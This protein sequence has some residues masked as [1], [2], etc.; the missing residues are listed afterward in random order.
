MQNG[1]I[2]I[3][4][5][6]GIVV[7]DNVVLN[8][9]HT[10][11]TLSAVQALDRALAQTAKTH[12]DRLCALGVYRYRRLRPADMPN[13]E[14]RALLAKTANAYAY[15]TVVTVL[16]APGLFNTTVRLFIAGLLSVSRMPNVIAESID[17]GVALL[18]VSGCQ[19][20]AVEPVLRRLVDRV[21]A[22]PPA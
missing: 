9:W 19:T 16:D 4:P 18:G 11:Y 22:P 12:G 5:E 1:E 6:G 3:L 10:A 20:T 21:F 8:A 17:E 14:T 13:A 15:K 2:E 7:V